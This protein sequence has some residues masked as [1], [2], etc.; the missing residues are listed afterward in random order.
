MTKK[1]IHWQ[2]LSLDALPD[3]A[4]MVD[5][6]WQDTQE[7]APLLAQV[8]AKPWVLDDATLQRT[9]RLYAER[10]VILSWH[11]RQL[12]RW[13]RAPLTPEQ[14]K[15]I[16]RLEGRTAE[17]TRLTATLLGL[18][19]EIDASTEGVRGACETLSL[20]QESQ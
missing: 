6:Y 14:A 19:E 2:W 11:T 4:A 8:K 17:S 18:A 16:D 1:A 7:M 9:I 12:A 5:D 20:P 10:L 13:R 15:E 3:F